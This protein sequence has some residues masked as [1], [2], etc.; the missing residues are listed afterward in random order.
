MFENHLE[1][2]VL[3]AKWYEDTWQHAG[4]TDGR[5]ALLC[6]SLRRASEVTWRVVEG[7]SRP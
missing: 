7:S 5:R 1:V 6:A 4:E 3:F 2:E